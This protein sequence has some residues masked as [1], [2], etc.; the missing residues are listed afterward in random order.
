MYF[1]SFFSHFAS[2]F[3][4]FAFRSILC[5]GYENS[6]DFVVYFFAALINSPEIRKVYSECF[7]FCGVFHENICKIHAKCETRKVYSQPN[8]GR[9]RTYVVVVFHRR[10]NS[11]ILHVVSIQSMI[12]YDRSLASDLDFW[13]IIDRFWSIKIEM[14]KMGAIDYRPSKNWKID[15]LLLKCMIQ[16]L[17]LGKP[18]KSINFNHKM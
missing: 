16:W 14:T 8:E 2:L 3:S 6:K 7:V 15:F 18:G 17:E 4:L 13:R 5:Q 10:A 11:N 12:K 1:V 9:C